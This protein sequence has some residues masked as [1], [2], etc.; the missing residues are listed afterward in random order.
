MA[1]LGASYNPAFDHHQGLLSK[2]YTAEGKKHKVEQKATL[3]WMICLHQRVQERGHF[4]SE[5]SAGLTGND[6]EDEGSTSS[7]EQDVDR[8]S[9][10]PPVRKEDEKR[11]K[12]EIQR[13]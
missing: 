6:S 8:I 10:N 4:L 9:M 11:R 1:H 5:M 2:V 7:L 13:S 3:L 12:K